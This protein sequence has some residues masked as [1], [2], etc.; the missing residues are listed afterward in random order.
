MRASKVP[1]RELHGAR[2][3][4]VLAEGSATQDPHSHRHN[5]IRDRVRGGWRGVRERYAR[6]RPHGL[7][8][9]RGC[10][11]L[12]ACLILCRGP[13]A[14]RSRRRAVYTYIRGAMLCVYACRCAGSLAAIAC[15]SAPLSCW[16]CAAHLGPLS[17]SWAV[18]VLVSAADV[19]MY[20]W[21]VTLSCCILRS[22]HGADIYVDYV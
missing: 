21:H 4:A 18:M 5:V 17:L 14:K 3:S 19:F 11:L 22:T 10:V 15:S 2:S 9:R 6:G 8:L 20:L 7:H 1:L 16:K 12:T 13:G